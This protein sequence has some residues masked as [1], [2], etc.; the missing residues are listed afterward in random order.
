MINFNDNA[1]EL[2]FPTNQSVLAAV[3]DAGFG[4][5]IIGYGPGKLPI[6]CVTLG[7]GKLPSILIT[8]GAHAGE[9][10]GVVGALH[11]LKTLHTDHQVYLVPLRD[12]F[13]WEGMS[14]CL[15]RALGRRVDVETPAQLATILREQGTVLYH[16]SAGDFLISQIGQFGFVT[17]LPPDDPRGPRDIERRLRALLRAKPALI[18]PLLGLRLVF[19]TNLA[20]VEGCGLFERAFSAWVNADGEVCELNRSFDRDAP[21]EVVCLRNLIDRVR[22]GLTIDLHEG[23][24]S[25][26]YVFV[27]TAIPAVMRLARAAVAGARQAG[28]QPYTLDE[29]AQRVDQETRNRLNM[30]EP[31]IIIGPTHSSLQGASFGTYAERYGSA[32]AT[33][34]GR[35]TGLAQ[36]A[37]WQVAAALAG[38]EMFTASVAAQ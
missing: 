1:P 27:T 3:Q 9:P 22:P 36:R 18:Q 34:T 25:G 14:A 15:S 30:P 17:M 26:F 28:A 23:Q 12:P 33:E 19:P 38:V 21:E 10:S 11:L 4:Y 5:E 31:G 32:L 2:E 37:R 8:A 16:E 20:G 7:G 29:L 13:A 24:G 6:V 35:W